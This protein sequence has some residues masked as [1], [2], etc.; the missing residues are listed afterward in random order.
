MK[1]KA[2]LENANAPQGCSRAHKYLMWARGFYIIWDLPD[3]G[4]SGDPRQF[5][6][7]GRPVRPAS[8]ASVG[9]RKACR[10]HATK[11]HPA[12]AKL[13]LRAAARPPDEGVRGST[14]CVGADASSAPRAKRACDG[15]KRLDGMRRNGF[16]HQRSCDCALKR[17][18]RRKACRRHAPKR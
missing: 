2:F 9:R 16:L 10:R 11:R 8:E 3:A 7:G 18:G 6:R 4:Y 14:A 1:L 15:V 5:W 12:A 13:R 17:V